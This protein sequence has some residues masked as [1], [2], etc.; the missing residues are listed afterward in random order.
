MSQLVALINQVFNHL[1]GSWQVERVIDGVPTVSGA[2]N[3]K[4]QQPDELLYTEHGHITL[5]T[6]KQLPTRQSYIYRF[7]VDGISVF[8]DEEPLR[9]FHQIHF[10]T[11][12]DGVLHGRGSHQCKEDMYTV[13][14]RFFTND[15]GQSLKGFQI[16]Y[17]V[18]GP[19]KHSTILCLYQNPT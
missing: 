16:E 8:F 2:A 10:E 5:P 15:A 3:F 4:I 13:A 7:N 9:L 17:K 6:G 11:N 19:L 1:A 14:Y 18:E 12:G